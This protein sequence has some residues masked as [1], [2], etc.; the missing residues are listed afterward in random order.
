MNAQA[1]CTTHHSPQNLTRCQRRKVQR[2]QARSPSW[3]KNCN[4]SG[5]R[6][7]TGLRSC[8]F[9]TK[10]CYPQKSHCTSCNHWLRLHNCK[11]PLSMRD[12]G[13]FCVREE[14]R[15]KIYFSV[16]I[17]TTAQKNRKRRKRYDDHDK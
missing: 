6:Q 10:N 7:Q 14:K 15:R 17:L 9:R 12:R 11:K 4:L 3:T 5:F 16:G 1:R 13:S 8:L 2:M